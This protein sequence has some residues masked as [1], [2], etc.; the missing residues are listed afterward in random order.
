MIADHITNVISLLEETPSDEMILM[1][2]NDDDNDGNGTF[3]LAIYIETHV[4][5]RNWKT[6]QEILNKQRFM[7][8]VILPP[9]TI[10]VQELVTRTTEQTKPLSI[11]ITYKHCIYTSNVYRTVM[12]TKVKGIFGG[13]DPL[14]WNA[15]TVYSGWKNLYRRTDNFPIVDCEIFKVTIDI[16]GLELLRR[17]KHRLSRT[18]ENYEKPIRESSSKY[19]S[20]VECEVFKIVRKS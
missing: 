2:Y 19:S 1:I 20:I 17:D 11:I 13:Y 3:I 5:Q 18:Q 14:A 16:F 4:N 9:R 6:L 7:V 10:L 12:I 8:S 15:N